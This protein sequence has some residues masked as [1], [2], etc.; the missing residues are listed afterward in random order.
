LTAGPSSSVL[1]LQ[2]LAAPINICADSFV[3]VTFHVPNKTN[4][5][6]NNRV[7]LYLANNASN[8]ITYEFG[9]F[10]MDTNYTRYGH[11]SQ[12]NLIRRKF[13]T[14]GTF[15]CAAVDTV[16]ITLRAETATQDTITFGEVATYG[17][18]LPKATLI[19]TADDQWRSWFTLGQY[20]LDSLG[21]PSTVFL[22][23]G[24]LGA[25]NKLTEREM[26]SIYARGLIDVGSHLWVH[27][28]STVISND[29]LMASIK[30]NWEFIR[31]K[32]WRGATLLAWPY[33]VVNRERDSIARASGV[34][35]FIRSVKGNSDGEAQAM[36][37]P[38]FVRDLTFLAAGVTAAN[39]TAIIDD[40]VLSKSVGL[41]GTHALCTGCTPD[42]N[43]WL[44]SDFITV[45]AHIKTKV[46]AGTLQVMGWSDYLEQYGGGFPPGRRAGMRP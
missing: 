26:D 6:N 37:N 44:Q 34:V 13:T 14:A 36:G 35:D 10:G 45:L 42:A 33:G 18:R 20:K 39:V 28:S 4:V 2:T 12:Y 11:W 41:L 16:I 23:G 27:D 31:R 19:F 9:S 40:M 15:N 8:Y 46:D 29:S 5:L 3:R 22:N 1:F 25:T 24:L 17:P 32:R 38:Y 7:D 21:Y 30:K 43:T